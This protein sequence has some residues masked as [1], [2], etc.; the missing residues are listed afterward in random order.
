MARAAKDAKTAKPGRTANPLP[1]GTLEVGVGLILAGISAYGFTVRRNLAYS[2]LPSELK[3]GAEV[4][5]EVF[6]QRLP[7]TVMRDR[8]LERQHAN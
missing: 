6:G 2:Y 3:P 1:E 7:A 5:V 8:V 4:D